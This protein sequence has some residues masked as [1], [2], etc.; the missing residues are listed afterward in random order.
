V[1]LADA[2]T[3]VL[4]AALLTGWSTPRITR[5]RTR[6]PEPG[7]TWLASPSSIR[8]P[9]GRRV[10]VGALLSVAQGMFVVLFVVFV[11]RR[12]GGEAG[13]VGLLR[14]CRRSAASP[15]AWCSARSPAGSRRGPWSRPAAWLR[16][17]LPGDL[18]RPALTTAP[19]LYLV[20]FAVVGVLIAA[21]LAGL[22]TVLLGPRRTS[23]AAG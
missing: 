7:G 9:A 8:P 14:G 3:F 11:L 18:E 22:T 6:R 12:L 4:A 20:L 10:A 23:S 5:A 2:G 16:R 1:V 19:P 15:A 21:G 13:E 17:G